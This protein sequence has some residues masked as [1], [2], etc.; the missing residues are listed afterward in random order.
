MTSTAS[1]PPVAPAVAPAVGG[2][3]TVRRLITYALLAATVFIA[4][5]GLS[6]LLDRLFTLDRV[7]VS[8]D[9]YGLATSLAS[10]LVA[11]PLAGLLWWLIWRDATCPPPSLLQKQR[12]PHRVSPAAGRTPRVE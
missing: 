8:F 1:T 3:Q 7:E 10:A 5:S 12:S 6:G 11:G 4:A 9:S 2:V